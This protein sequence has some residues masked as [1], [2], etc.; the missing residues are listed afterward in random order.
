MTVSRRRFLGLVGG[1]AG[2]A[3]GG[4]VAWSRLLDEHTRERDRQ[5][6][7]EASGRIL[8]VVEMGGGNDGL[9]TLV[10][11]DGRYRDAR[12]TLAVPEQQ[13]LA[14][15]GG[16]GYGLHPS[17]EPLTALWDGGHLAAMQGVG[18]GGQ[19]RSH[20]AATDVWHAGGVFPFTT[21]WLGRWLDAT[22]DE[23]S[24][25][26]RAIGLGTDNRILAAEHSLSTVVKDPATFDLLVPAGA[27]LDADAVIAAFEATARP[28]SEDPLVSAT[29]AAIPATIEAV[30]LLRRATADAGDPEE[31]AAPP[32]SATALLGSVARIVELDVG[33]ELFVVGVDGF[34][35]HAGQTDAHPGLLAD[36]GSGI[37]GFL[38]EMARQGRTEDVLVVTTSEFGRRVAE[39]ASVGTDHG[40]ANVAFLAGDA[41][42][43]QIVGD[44]D[45]VHLDEGDVPIDIETR[46]LYA[47][48][49]DW[50]GGPTDEILDGSF[51]RYGLITA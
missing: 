27:D 7:G 48:A 8:V 13:V 30:D 28:A 20:F 42:N 49:L 51:D 37:S 15:D 2:V 34:D 46:S 41:V 24:S 36:I 1:T 32:G 18:F 9:N 33:T 3:V 31:A 35:T 26:L 44:L 45:L 16:S 43:G 4:A 6:A 22:G 10:P 50:L 17:L 39:N 5:P 21:S 11:P 47:N 23:S 14:L 40:F 25:P 38:A 12:P 29:Q 19:S